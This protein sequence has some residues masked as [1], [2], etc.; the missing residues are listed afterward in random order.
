MHVYLGIPVPEVAAALGI[1][2]GTAKSRLSRAL[3]QMRRAI[4]P[5]SDPGQERV[6]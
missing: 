1:P 5:V 2:L 3:A 6:A 4:G